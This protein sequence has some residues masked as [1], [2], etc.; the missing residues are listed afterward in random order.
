MF[1]VTG[2]APGDWEIITFIM[3]AKSKD[4]KT[5]KD[6]RPVANVPFFLT[7]F[8]HTCCFPVLQIFRETHQLEEEHTFCAGYRTEKHLATAKLV[9]DKLL[10]VN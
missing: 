5:P 4:A 3:L 6:F 10:S 8:L 7:K 2:E 9:I 1:L